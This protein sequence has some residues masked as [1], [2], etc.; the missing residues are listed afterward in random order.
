ML[1][2]HNICAILRIINME[3]VMKKGII[4]IYYG[5]G[6]GKSAAALGSAMMRAS[7]GQNVTLI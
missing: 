7:E 5:E 4:Q 2:N 1:Q 6:R 3:D